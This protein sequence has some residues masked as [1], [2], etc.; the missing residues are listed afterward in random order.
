MLQGDAG[1][2]DGAELGSNGRLIKNKVFFFKFE[3]FAHLKS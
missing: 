3:I 2:V 1:G